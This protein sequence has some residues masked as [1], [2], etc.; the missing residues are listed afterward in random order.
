MDI[1][2][3]VLAHWLSLAR[4]TPL[5]VSCDLDGTLLP[6]VA[7]PS[8]SRLLPGL[9]ELLCG[10]AAL[11]GLSLAIVSG[12]PREDLER[13]LAP[14]LGVWLVAEHGGWR[15]RA[16]AWEAAVDQQPEDVEPLAARL[17]HLAGAV[18]GALVERKTWSVTLHYRLVP[19]LE[20]AALLVAVDAALEEWLAQA[21]GFERLDGVEMLE[22]RP[23]RM[24]KSLAGVSA[25]FLQNHT[26]RKKRGGLENVRSRFSRAFVAAVGEAMKANS[27]LVMRL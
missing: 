21:P 27:R 10:L 23:A 15:R 7:T 14:I 26:L 25:L 6:F 9:A 18:P 12:R 4:H 13:L 20:R 19:E 3:D 8:A 16:G 1:S 17:Q 2:Q 5:G 11:L 24:R 22:V